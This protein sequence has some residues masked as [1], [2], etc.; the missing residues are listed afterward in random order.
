MDTSPFLTRFSQI[1]PVLDY[2]KKQ[3]ENEKFLKTLEITATFVLII[4]FTY[5]A[6]RPTAL[7]IASLLGEIESKKILKTELNK[8]I[9]N[10]ILAQDLFSQVEGK[11]SIVNNSLPDRPNYFDAV[12]QIKNNCLVGCNLGQMNFNFEADPNT[13]PN[14]NIETYTVNV[15]DNG[16][17]ESAVDLATK[18]LQNQRLT[19][20]GSIQ[21]SISQT[22]TSA[23]S[24]SASRN[25]LGTNFSTIFYYWPTK[26]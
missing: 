14:K 20:I 18:V 5:F 2:L 21:F 7:T 9:N 25:Q 16:S 22:T 3:Q 1:Q 8:K 19:N 10:I 13:P 6:I 24:P 23:S 17:F 11:Y 15:I 12:N 26:K 4:F